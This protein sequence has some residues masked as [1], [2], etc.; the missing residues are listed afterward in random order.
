MEI[1]RK[2]A[3]DVLQQVD[4][5]AKEVHGKLAYGRAGPILTIWGCIWIVCFTLGHF[6]PKSSG[7]AWLVGDAIGIVAS[8]YIGMRGR[9]AT[10]RRDSSKRLGWKM[11]WFW[12]FLFVYGDI[13]LAVLWPWRGEQLGVFLITLVMFAYVMI[14][15][16][17][18]MKFLLWL[19]LSITLVAGAAYAISLADP[20][21]L[22]Y[23]DLWLG[24][25]CGTALLA[26]GL[27]LT[28]RWR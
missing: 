4:Q 15:L 26:S 12:V 6:A 28:F 16:W 25:T 5:V 19:G 17:S 11:F 24:C 7:V 8:I 21:Y 20:R 1:T 2:E 3:E 14:G 27:Y 22:R 13:W 10:V 18:E 9:T 23:L